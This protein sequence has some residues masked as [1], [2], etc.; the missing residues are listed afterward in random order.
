MF[1]A[2]APKRYATLT[3]EEI[4]D[5]RQPVMINIMAAV[6]RARVRF[7]FI[8]LVWACGIVCYF[9]DSLKNWRGALSEFV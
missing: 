4:L 2:G 6:M 8:K 7:T 1:V 9:A 3:A 5:P